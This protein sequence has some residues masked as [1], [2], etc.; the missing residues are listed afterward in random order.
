MNAA[1]ELVDGLRRD[2][3]ALRV[4]GRTTGS[5]AIHARCLAL[6]RHFRERGIA[7]GDPVVVLVP[8]GP[9]FAAALLALVWLGA[10]PVLIE[11][12]SAPGAWR[13]R[14]DAA[15]ARFAVVD[16]RLRWVWA[17]PG[18]SGWLS[19]RGRVLPPAPD[20]PRIP[21]PWRARGSLDAVER[22]GADPALIVF[23]SGT[24][25]A[26]RA[27]V[28]AHGTLPHWLAAVRRVVEDLEIRSYLAETPQQIF[29]ALLLGATCH[30]VPGT[31]PARVE[32]AARAMQEERIE[33]WFGSPWLWR[34][35][36]DGGGTV[37]AHLRAVLLG[38][39]PV[40][41]GF[42]ADFLG[43]VPPSTAVRCVYGLTEI[44]PAAVVDGR[45]K[46]AREVEG[47]WVGRLTLGTEA[48]LDGDGPVGEL[49]LASPAL[50]VRYG[51]EPI[52]PWLRTGDL[53]S[54]GPDG[55]VLKGRTK[56]MI[57][58]RGVNLYPGVLEGLLGGEV[59]L[60]GVWDPS[61]E[62]ERVVLFH[63]G[64]V[65]DLGRLGEDARPDA[66]FAVDALPR[67][68]RQHKVDKGALRAVAAARLGLS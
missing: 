67:A 11:P 13:A 7:A 41:R 10:V 64:P 49:L 19:R 44:G 62:D 30:L 36:V 40:T 39:S 24:T 31:G 1:F 8:P 16:P 66:V 27:V 52:G 33:A 2:R 58:R 55:V 17:V 5:A 15:G 47:D 53:A 43:R 48:R 26:P 20:L 63:V 32:R 57:V 23:T 35:W 28:H 42:L 12:Q 6:A 14:L 3:P 54:L 50:A 65:G 59:A 18:L 25:S 22:S 60:V 37:P 45:E 56:D 46:A 29:Y 38:S 21:L 61:A 9:E 34:S 4:G 68:G 51:A